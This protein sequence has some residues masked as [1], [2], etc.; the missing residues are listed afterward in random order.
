VGY[1]CLALKRMLAYIVL[2]L[3]STLENAAMLLLLVGN[4]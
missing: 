2:C 3:F 4:C 1:A